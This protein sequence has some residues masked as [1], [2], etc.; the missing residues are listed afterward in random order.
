M[1]K[2]KAINEVKKEMKN[3]R[4]NKETKDLNFLELRDY[5]TEKIKEKINNG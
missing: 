4:N 2:F 5:Y 3:W 1:N